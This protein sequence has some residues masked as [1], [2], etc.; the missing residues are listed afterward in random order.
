MNLHTKKVRIG[1]VILG[2]LLSLAVAPA[3]PAAAA[4]PTCTT[5]WQFYSSPTGT[6]INFVPE[7]AG[8]TAGNGIE[9]CQLKQGNTGIGVRGLQQTLV[10][11]YK[12]SI[13]IDGQFGPAT[14]SA[15]RTAQSKANVS[16]DGIAGPETLYALSYIQA[17]TPSTNYPCLGYHATGQNFRAKTKQS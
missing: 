7:P 14:E 10:T 1:A 8:E 15:L 17:S 4:Y 11:C 13:S 5:I 3:A 6:Y 12:Q 16:A 2:G 9:N